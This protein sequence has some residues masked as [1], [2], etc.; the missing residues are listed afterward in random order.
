[1]KI[2]NKIVAASAMVAGTLVGGSVAAED[3]HIAYINKLDDAPWFV[4]EAQGAVDRAAELGVTLTHQGVQSDPNKAISALEAAIGAGVDGVAIVVP[5]QQIG[6]AIMQMAADAGIPI[7]AVDDGIMDADG[8]AAPFV[9]FSGVAV[10][11]QVG[12]ALVGYHQ[13][14]GW[15]D[16]LAP[17]TA[18][19]SVEVQ[20]LSVCMDRTENANAVLMN[21]L[22]ATEDNIIHVPY[23]PGTL[24]KAL[25]GVSQ[26]IVA[27]PSVERW[28][29]HSCNDDGVAGAVR[30][31]EQAGYT[32]D[33]M[34]G[35]GIDGQR[36]CEEFK[37]DDATGFR[38]S[39]Y[40]D[41]AI[42]GATAVQLLHDAITEGAEIPE[43]TIIEGIL[44]T[45]EDDKGVP[46]CQD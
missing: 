12:E 27:F 28:L 21:A 14:L 41:S 1:M 10:G 40:V 38:A 17:N 33:D 25:Q 23:D 3:V 22:G 32:R 18:I 15:G 35:V 37:K 19:L 16:T 9:G 8:N 24:D 5:D 7:I 20:S 45:R 2:F 30:A 29:I 43:S 31:L 44:I 26:T 36:A 46:D 42:H 39:M 6:P 4:R 11:I 34:A 13:S